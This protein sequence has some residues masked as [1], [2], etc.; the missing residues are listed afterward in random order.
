MDKQASH[1]WGGCGNAALL[2]RRRPSFSSS[3]TIAHGCK[4]TPSKAAAINAFC[5]KGLLEVI[6]NSRVVEFWAAGKNIDCRVAVLRPGVNRY[7][8][9]GDYHDAAYAVGTE[10]VEHGFNN[11]S[12]AR[13]DRGAQKCFDVA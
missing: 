6:T 8:R 7:V 9:F 4:Y 11:P 10:V 5:S 1:S 13:A 3:K 12:A 2:V